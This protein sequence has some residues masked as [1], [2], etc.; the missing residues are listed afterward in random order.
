M[1]SRFDCAPRSEVEPT[2]HGQRAPSR[3]GSRAAPRPIT[4]PYPHSGLPGYPAGGTEQ[5]GVG[6]DHHR[7]GPDHASSVRRPTGQ[8]RP[9]R[10]AQRRTPT[11][12]QLCLQH[13]I[14]TALTWRCGSKVSDLRS[15]ASWMASCGTRRIGSSI[16]TSRS[17]IPK[18]LPAKRTDNRTLMPRSRSS[19]E[20]SQAPHRAAMR[21]P[22]S[23]LPAPGPDAA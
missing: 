21:P 14:P 9:R 5:A 19:E 15:S 8:P 1:L 7:R 6:T 12:T 11:T 22:A 18:P 16:R 20:L 10:C 13:P 2:S 23:R 4:P 3:G 17:V